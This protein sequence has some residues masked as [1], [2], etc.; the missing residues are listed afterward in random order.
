M[1]LLFALKILSAFLHC[2]VFILLLV[3]LCRRRR[4][5]PYLDWRRRRHQRQRKTKINL[6][7]FEKDG[8][9]YILFNIFNKKQGSNLFLSIGRVKIF[10]S[11]SRKIFVKKQ[12]HHLEAFLHL[13]LGLD[14]LSFGMFLMTNQFF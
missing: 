4:L 1:C 3:L 5:C 2:L 13:Y 6:L 8:R 9:I 7:I 14:G 10:S 12:P 11:E